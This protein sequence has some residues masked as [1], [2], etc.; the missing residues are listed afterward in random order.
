M[1]R[2]QP[3]ASPCTRCRLSACAAC[4]SSDRT[5]CSGGGHSYEGYSVAPGAVTISLD[6]MNTTTVSG[7]VVNSR[8][9]LAQRRIALTLT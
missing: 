1:V 5:E 8:W 6:W 4:P 9:R 7:W 3:D 2:L